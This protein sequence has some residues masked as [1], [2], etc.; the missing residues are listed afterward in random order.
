MLE[1]HPNRKKDKYNPY[2]LTITEGHYYLSFKDGR[3]KQQNIEIDEMLYQTFDRFELEDISHLNRVSRHIEHSELTDETLN[4]RAFY[5]AGRIED[6]V[7][8][9]IEYE[10]LHRAVSE[11]PEVQRRRL[12]LY[13]FGELTYEQIAK[14]EGCT[15][16]AV[17]FS[18]D[19]AVE[20]LK[21]NFK[22]F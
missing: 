7:S 14:L 6:I 3:G 10:Q 11:L 18:V 22:I 15:K 2:T 8:E 16:R 19:I 5:K 4:D 20:K 12:K 1:K 9:S 17:K 13:F 21:K